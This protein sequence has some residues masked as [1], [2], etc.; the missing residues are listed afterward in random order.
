M[1]IQWVCSRPSALLRDLKMNMAADIDFLHLQ[2]PPEPMPH[3]S[4]TPCEVLVMEIC[5]TDDTLV[6]DW[7]SRYPKPATRPLTLVLLP[8][9]AA[10]QVVSCLDAGV[11]RCMS[12]DSDPRLIQAMIRSMVLRC[13]GQAATYT[14]H[15]LLRFDHATGTLFHPS[16]RVP[17]THRETLVI[18]V[19][20][21][22]LQ[23]HV[24][25]REILQALSMQSIKQANAALVSLYVHRINRKILPYGACIG[26]KRGYGYKPQAAPCADE[27][28]MKIAWLG[29]LPVNKRPTSAL[30]QGTGAHSH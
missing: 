28:T 4:S 21:R 5:E 29:A 12:R 3:R 25:P 23:R 8:E 13:R 26:F 17:L 9:P 24:H 14:E 19:L 2:G 10:A 27:E 15:G 1:G 20:F 16:G 7:L 30:V 11:D 6:R 18:G 22:Q